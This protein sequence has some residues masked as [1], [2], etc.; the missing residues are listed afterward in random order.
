M[1]QLKKAE[2]KFKQGIRVYEPNEDGI[3]RLVPQQS[4]E[5]SQHITKPLELNMTI[6]FYN[7]HA[8]LI[9]DIKKVCHQLACA[10][11]N[12]QFTKACNLQRHADRC[13]KAETLVHCPG[14]AVERP[15]AAYEKAFYLNQMPVR[16]Q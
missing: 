11:C 9:R 16:G 5:H 14:E 7:D 2:E 15:Q 1:T 3:W 8:F 6:G 4:S 10:H 13:T 12:Q